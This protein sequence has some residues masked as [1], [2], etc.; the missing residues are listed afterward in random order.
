M[1][2]C[3]NCGCSLSFVSHK[4]GRKKENIDPLIA[5]A[6]SLH[7]E[8]L[9][10]N[11]IAVKLD[12]YENKIRQ[13]LYSFGLKPNKKP[14]KHL[15]RNEEIIALYKSPMTLEEV[16]SHF[17]ITRERVRQVLRMNGIDAMDGGRAMKSFTNIDS[18]INKLREK[19][20]KK[21]SIIYQ[22]YGVSLPFYE[23][24]VSQYGTV[25][26]PRSPLNA[27]REQKRNAKLRA[28]DWQLSFK[29][30]WDIWQESGKW[31]LRGRG[32]GYC[33]GRHGDD[34]AYTKDNVYICTI[35]QNFSDSYITKPASQRH[36]KRMDG[37][38]LGTGKGYTFDKN[39][40]KNPYR[41]Q[42]RG[43]YLGSFP[44]P[45]MA[46]E[47][48]LQAIDEYKTSLKKELA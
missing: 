34:G 22:K 5:S 6:I 3:P 17:D 41:T 46:R 36:A 47:R 37:F 16:A 12:T 33:M 27:F 7:K 24:I 25:S 42:F 15:A 9:R 31:S 19:L 26:I 32:K 45:E 11:A 28:I 18:K 8:G 10:L 38:N 30:W 21:E 20:N 29:D 2:N 1:K 40:R 48:Y 43:S 35:G 39:S 44:T 13:I 23:A 14:S 4:S